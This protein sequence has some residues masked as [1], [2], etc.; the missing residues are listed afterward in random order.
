MAF[1][2]ESIDSFVPNATMRKRFNNGL[3]THYMIKPVA[4]YAMHDIGYDTIR[5][6]AVVD[7][8]GN[9]VYD[10]YGIPMVSEAPVL[11]YRTTEGAVGHDY[12]WTPVE[13]LDEA[14]NTVTAYGERQ[15]F[16]KP[17]DEVPADQIFGVTNPPEI[18]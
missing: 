5:E 12:D 15:F 7:E 2:Y 9:P 13:M 11:G 16:C 8:Y 6:E 18:M 17:I 3:F 14:G 10:D 4:G 1:T